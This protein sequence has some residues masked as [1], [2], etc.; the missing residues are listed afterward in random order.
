MQYSARIK[1]RT[2]DKKTGATQTGLSIQTSCFKGKSESA[3]MA[4]LNDKY[5]NTREIIIEDIEWK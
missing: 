3:V 5:H 1:Y 4:Y 2:K